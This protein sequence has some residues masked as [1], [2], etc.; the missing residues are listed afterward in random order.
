MREVN[1]GYLVD[2]SQESNNYGELLW[3]YRDAAGI[4]HYFYQKPVMEQYFNWLNA[5]FTRWDWG[6]SVTLLP[7]VEVANII[8]LKL[9]YTIKVNIWSVIISVPLGILLGVIAALKKNKMTDNII[10]TLVMIF[11]SIPSFVIITFLLLI[12]CYNLKWLPTQWP[13]DDAPLVQE[14]LDI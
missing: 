4:T 10:S 5:I 3:K 8:A 6:T 12:F 11:I 14:Y 2:L 9:P 7:N 1:L 13:V